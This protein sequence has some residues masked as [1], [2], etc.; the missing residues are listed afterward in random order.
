MDMEY[1]SSAFFHKKKE[2]PA[3]KIESHPPPK[4]FKFLKKM[5]GLYLVIV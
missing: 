1:K 5:R 4:G 2:S 3:S